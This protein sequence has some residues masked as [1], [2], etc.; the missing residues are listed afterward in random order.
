[1]LK[2]LFE[3][4]NSNIL[5]GIIREGESMKDSKKKWLYNEDREWLRNGPEIS[6]KEGLE[7]TGEGKLPSKWDEFQKTFKDDIV[8]D[9]DGKLW[10]ILAE[11]DKELNL[12]GRE[13]RNKIEL[14]QKKSFFYSRPGVYIVKQSKTSVIYGKHRTHY[15]GEGKNLAQRLR[16]RSDRREEIFHGGSEVTIIIKCEGKIEEDQF[17]MHEVRLT[18]ERMISDLIEKKWPSDAVCCNKPSWCFIHKAGVEQVGEVELF[19][20]RLL[21][22]GKISSPK[23]G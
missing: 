13:S 3:K 8:K 19:V 15:I 20:R 17:F 10:A 9:P 2:L 14:T 1:M 18:C 6:I 4:L 16:N 22:N 11:T 23:Q 5:K 21:D 12:I 7:C